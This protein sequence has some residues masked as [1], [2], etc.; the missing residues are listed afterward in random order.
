MQSASE[1]LEPAEEEARLQMRRA[2]AGAGPRA[3]SFGE[4]CTG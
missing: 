1:E 3:L 2:R 4:G